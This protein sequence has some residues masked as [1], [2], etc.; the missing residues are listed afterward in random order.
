[1][2]GESS[3]SPVL[4]YDGVCGV[5]NSA[6][7][8]ILR[9]DPNGPLRFAALDSDFARA[10]F[11]RH[12]AIGD[13]DSMVFV[14]Q[15]GQPTE[16]VAVRSAAALR[17]ADYLGGPWKLLHAARV[18]PATLRDWLYDKFAGVRYR[19]FGKHDTCPLPPP[20]VRARF[21]DA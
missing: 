1:M 19:I 16:R 14:D 15:P 20:E 11:D 7:Q 6:V 9:F 21:L 12:P 10:V 3:A 17:V 4:L 5:C 13:V 8:T 18:I 2:S